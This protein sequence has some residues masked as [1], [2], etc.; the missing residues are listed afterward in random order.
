[1]KKLIHISMALLL[2]S[3]VGPAFAATLKWSMPGDSL[4]L[5]PHAQN[6]GPT[7]MVSRQVYETL[8]TRVV[9][10]SIEAQLA[11]SW[12]TTDPETWVFSLRKGVVFSDGSAL[13]ASDV[14]FS[15]NRALTGASDMIELI[16]SITSVKAIDGNTVEI[17]TEGPNPILLNQLSQIFIMSEAWSKKNG[18]EQSQ[19][20]D[21]SQETYCSINAL[22]TGPFKITLREQNTRTVFERNDNWWG[23]QSQHNIDTIEL[24][25]IKNDATRVAALLS[26]DIDFTNF[27]PAQDIQRINGSALHKVESTPQARTIF[28]GM[29]QGS[30]ELRSSNI[31]GKNP[32]KDKRVRLAMYHALDM[33]AIQDKVMRGLSEPAGMITFPGVQGYTKELDTRLP[34]DPNM[35]KKLLADA[36]YPDGFEITLDCP[37][38]RYINDEA[39]C[40]AAVGMLAKVGI[41]VN[42]DAQ[43]KSI[44]FKDLQNDLSDFYMLGWGVPTFDS[45]YV[46]SFLLKSDGSWNKVGFNDARVDELVGTMLTETNLDQRNANIAEAWAI[47]QD[48]MPY[49]PLHHQVISWG[50]K[51]N[52]DVPIRTN[53]EPLFRFAKVN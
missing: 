23:N 17:K 6:E 15:I 33:D 34:Y 13:K 40:V 10:M 46:Y 43:P 45:H 51:S 21:A 38:N 37:N 52:V 41:K 27:T 42:L 24:L 36:G 11:T 32:L 25:P 31:K 9:D 20:F 8:V 2:A 50:S 1:M 49:L 26:G 14:V 44:H 19:D 3:F 16:D 4:T 29:D 18:C 39:I 22:G 53:N 12:K 5:D 7:H 35:S 47:V 28:F 30:D 48:N